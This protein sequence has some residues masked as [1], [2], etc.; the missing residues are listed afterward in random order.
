MTEICKIQVDG[1]IMKAISVTM[2]PYRRFDGGVGRGAG[3]R[4]EGGAAHGC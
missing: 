4:D 3:A 2:V 1:E